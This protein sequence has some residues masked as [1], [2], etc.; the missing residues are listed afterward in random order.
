VEIATINFLQ[1]FPIAIV[2]DDCEGQRA[3]GRGIR[4]IVAAI[5]EEAGATA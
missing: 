4:Q 2:D 1:S 3:D 5:A